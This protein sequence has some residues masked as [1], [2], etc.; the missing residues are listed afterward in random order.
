MFCLCY[1][2]LYFVKRDQKGR[3]HIHSIRSICFIKKSA[4][5]VAGNLVMVV[6]FTFQSVFGNSRQN[7]RHTSARGREESLELYSFLWSDLPT[8]KQK[9]AARVRRR[10]VFRRERNDDRIYVCCSQATIHWLFTETENNN[11]FG[12]C[13]RTDLNKIWKETIK[14]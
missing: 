4:F 13:T 14:K 9:V 5:N 12:I 8:S 1:V 7:P 6:K 10:S 2:L 11:C 3:N